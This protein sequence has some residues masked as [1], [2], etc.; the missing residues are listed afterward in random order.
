MNQKY[1]RII[2]TARQTAI[3]AAALA[4]AA[5]TPTSAQNLHPADLAALALLQ[6][7]QWAL[8]GR[9]STTGSKNLCVQDMRALLQIEH[10]KAQCN[11]FVIADGAK[12]TIVHYTC[13]GQG[14]GQTTLRVE[15]PRL[16]QIDSQGVRDN[17]PFAVAFEGRRVGECERLASSGARPH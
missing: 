6:P 8:H 2:R 14:H 4:W 11:R 9:D 1:V 17:E 13:P 3:A 10:G 16:I 12:M 7:G 15:T 5:L